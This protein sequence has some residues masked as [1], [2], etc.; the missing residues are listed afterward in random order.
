M[1][2]KQILG[3]S[4]ALLLVAIPLAVAQTT[5]Q[6]TPRATEIR[7]RIVA[8]ETPAQDAQTARHL[9][10]IRTRSGEEV[11][12]DLGPQG[13]C[14]GCLQVGDRV[15]VQAMHAGTE[16]A[17]WMVQTMHVRRTGQ[18]MRFRDERGAPLDSPQVGPGP[19]VGDRMRMR[20][21]DRIHEPG[22]G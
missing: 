6:Q 20:Q 1:K 4:L 2:T 8:I 12:L 13:P 11:A 7:G 9:V 16:G 5:D 15:R 22:T 14:E 10:R 19:G 3:A 21:R 18:V 17:P